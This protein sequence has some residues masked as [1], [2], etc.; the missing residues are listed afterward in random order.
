MDDKPTNEP[1]DIKRLID[2]AEP[3]NPRK[4][5]GKPDAKGPGGTNVVDIENE[6]ALHAAF[7]QRIKEADYQQLLFELAPEVAKSELRTI[8]KISLLKAIGKPA[9]ADV[10]LEVLNQHLREL[11]I[12]P[13]GDAPIP[14][15]PKKP[16][17][18]NGTPVRPECGPRYL[19][20]GGRICKPNHQDDSLKP[21]CDWA[22]LIVETV[23]H[24]SGDEVEKFLMIEG[25]LSNGQAL[26]RI[27]V[28]ASAFAGMAW[29]SK[30]GPE[31]NIY[32][33]T[34]INDQVRD[35]LQ[36]ISKR[37]G[38][39]PQRTVYTHTG[40]RLIEGEWR[41]LHCGGA[42][43]KDGNRRD[44]E[45]NPGQGYMGLYRLPEP[46]EDEALGAA[47]RASLVFMELAPSRPDIG[48]FS[49][50][51][52]YRAPTAEAA[53]ID[54]GGWEYGS[55]G[56]FKTEVA[57]LA[58]GH[59]G[60][61]D[62]R[63]L[64]GN[65]TDSEG[66]IEHK[67]HAAKDALIV[68]DDFRPLGGANE[69]NKLHAKADRIFRG[70]GNQQGR[71]TLTV[72]RK[73]RAASHARGFVL[74]TGEDLPRGQSLRARL[75]VVEVGKGEID[76]A[77]LTEL[78]EAAR[79]GLFRQ[80]M[81]AYLKWL[82]P[83][84]TD[85]KTRLPDLIRV[86]REEAIAMGLGLAHARTA[87][88]YASLRAGLCLLA[89]F[90]TETGA[91]SPGEAAD[92]EEQAEKALRALM[93]RQA[94][95]Q[96]EEDEVRRFFALMQSALSAGRRHVSDRHNQGAPADLP[97]AW[98]WR[99]IQVQSEDSGI[100]E[101]TKPQGQ[102]VGWTDGQTLW[103]DGEAA[104]ATAQ[105]YAREQGGLF[106]IGKVTLW[107]RIHERGL[108]TAN[109]FEAGKLRKLAVNQ[110]INGRATPVYAL[111]AQ[112]FENEKLCNI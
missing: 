64:P 20:H 51:A 48:A 75:T 105:V 9:A 11:G 91:L 103:L 4:S 21:L 109:T 70:V 12:C 53:P 74:A 27:E 77:K 100:I 41:Y 79:S 7:M 67:T 69:V 8:S 107:K 96:A 5:S 90:A 85:L 76:R 68:I 14:E 30:W 40:W 81:A 13:P 98:G 17:R 56:N 49:L 94:D 78:Q 87:S 26:E 10:S 80:G 58:L 95:N 6:I 104:Y 16:N 55:T 31:A 97:H 112:V 52:I 2:Q 82:A 86:F 45:V 22:G 111:S 47:I 23:T 43:G 83:Q 88:D 101:H 19:V 33:G 66:N 65:F 60:E 71:E 15:E 42:L 38:P 108:L 93:A 18:R 84:M 61:F 106:E 57:A 25:R 35:A 99:A 72:N 36:D 1:T 54:H 29:V 89:E 92:F 73:E 24:D 102:R 34:S 37:S 59:F 39:I 3:K 32:A 28:P 44:V 63:C 50:A 110:W 46:P 62:G